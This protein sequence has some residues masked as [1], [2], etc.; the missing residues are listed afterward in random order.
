MKGM[1]TSSCRDPRFHSRSNRSHNSWHDHS[2]SVDAPTEFILGICCC[3]SSGTVGYTCRDCLQERYA[4][5]SY[6]SSHGNK[7]VDPYHWARMKGK[8][9]HYILPPE[10]LFHYLEHQSYEIGFDEASSLDASIEQNKRDVQ[11]WE[12]KGPG[13]WAKPL[14]EPI[15]PI[16]LQALWAPRNRHHRESGWGPG[17]PGWGPGSDTK[18]KNSF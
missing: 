14:E 18:K 13:F 1:D 2:V 5:A 3:G 15:D 7:K 11:C 10:N 16:V 12:I 6:P 17:S 9:L 8:G 4:V